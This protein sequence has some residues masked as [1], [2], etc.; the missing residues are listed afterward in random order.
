MELLG[1]KFHRN[2]KFGIRKIKKSIMNSLEGLIKGYSEE[3]S[4]T[5]HFVMSSI[6][7]LLGIF[8]KINRYEW[9]FTIILMGLILCIELLNTAIEANVDLT[10]ARIH[11][12]AKEAK[13]VGSAATFIMSIFA[14]IGEIIIFYPYFIEFFNI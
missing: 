10:T 11:P 4:L 14:L 12:L 2:K 6:V 9:V 7:V 13:D 3:Q 1:K 8:F 5:I